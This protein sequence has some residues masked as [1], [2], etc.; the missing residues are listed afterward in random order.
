MVVGASVVVVALVVVVV[1]LAGFV[2]VGT[3]TNTALNAHDEASSESARSA[4]SLLIFFRLATLV[5]IV[6]ASSFL[7]AVAI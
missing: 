1:V 7:A 4:L 5:L 6:A 3:S 2:S